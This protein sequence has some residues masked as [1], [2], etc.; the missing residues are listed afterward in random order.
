MATFGTGKEATA[1]DDGIRANL[2]LVNQL[3]IIQRLLTTCLSLL[4]EGS[5]PDCTIRCGEYEWKAHRGIL[6]PRNIYFDAAFNKKFQVRH[7]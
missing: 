2:K 5:F 4:F 7:F 3:A 1:E 6:C